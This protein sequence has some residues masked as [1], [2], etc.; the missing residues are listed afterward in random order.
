MK[1]FFN[2]IFVLDDVQ[3]TCFIDNNTDNQAGVLKIQHLFIRLKD[4]TKDFAI[5]KL[6][7]FCP[8][9]VRIPNINSHL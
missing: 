4:K 3:L 5:Q 2:A 6:E 8:D 9:Y 7:L 1:N